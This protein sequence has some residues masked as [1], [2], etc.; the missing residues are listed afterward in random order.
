M[1]PAGIHGGTGQV[2]VDTDR[3]I[4]GVAG[5]KIAAASDPLLQSWTEH[6]VNTGGDNYL[7]REGGDYYLVRP[8]HGRLTTLELLRS[9]DLVQW[10]PLGDFLADGHYTDP[11]TDCSCPNLLDLGNGRRLLLFFAHN[12]GPQYYI[13]AADLRQGRF[14][15]EEHGRMNYGPVMR[16]SLHAPS[17]FVGP[18]G[19]CIALWNVFECRVQEDFCGARGGLMSLPRRLSLNRQSTG[20]G[21]DKRELNPLCIEPI[22]E[23]ASLR[24]PPV[25]VR[26]VSVPANGEVVLSGIR[27]KAMELEAVVDPRQAREVG[28][29]VLRSPHGEEQTTIALSLHAWAWPWKG[30]RRELVLDVSQASLSPAVA[31]RTPEVGPLYLPDGEPLRLRVFVDR[32]IVE[33]FANGRQ[34]LTLRAYPTREDSTGVSVFARGSEA[35]LLSLDAYP[36]KSI[37][38][39]L[40]G[41]EGQ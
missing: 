33:V 30:N 24:L 40:K 39:E 13:G 12:Q 38:P 6:A 32:S 21:F 23:L 4:L 7:W 14:T 27:G 22:E 9:P 8:R 28:L 36:M 20:G 25:R 5:S 10:E 3:V 31:S 34:C 2:W 19:R 26:D 18:D 41:E 11:G 37:W 29:R 15:I 1:L 35:S 16:G 17:G